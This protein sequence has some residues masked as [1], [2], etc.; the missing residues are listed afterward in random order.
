MFSGDARRAVPG[1]LFRSRAAPG[2][3][4]LPP[5]SSERYGWHVCPRPVWSGR[6]F[7]VV[8]FKCFIAIRSFM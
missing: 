4:I 6:R 7:A 3:H 1:A 8:V 2:R 5:C